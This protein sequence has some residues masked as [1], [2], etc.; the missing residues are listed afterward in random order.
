MPTCTW[1]TGVFPA[2]SLS[3]PLSIVIDPIDGDRRSRQRA[4]HALFFVAF[5]LLLSRGVGLV[6]TISFHVQL[7]FTLPARFPTFLRV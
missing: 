4:R 7:T 6:T 2:F 1:A 5:F 3:L